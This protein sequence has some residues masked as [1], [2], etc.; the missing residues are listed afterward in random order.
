MVC[1]SVASEAALV[2]VAPSI[3]TLTLASVTDEGSRGSLNVPQIAAFAAGYEYGPG[4]EETSVGAVRSTTSA[5]GEQV[6]STPDTVARQLSMCRPS[7]SELVGNAERNGG[8]RVATTLPST[9][10]WT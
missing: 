2:T 10:T 1:P 5:H 3:V 8:A 4:D 6:A 7:N 9:S